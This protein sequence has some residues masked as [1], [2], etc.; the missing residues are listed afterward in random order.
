M[1]LK[2]VSKQA[3]KPNNPAKSTI[4]RISKMRD[5]NKDYRAI[6][7]TGRKT[8]GRYPNLST[9]YKMGPRCKRPTFGLKWSAA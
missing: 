3:A 6:S 7:T 5:S 1:K 4:S 2:S 9:R 8:F